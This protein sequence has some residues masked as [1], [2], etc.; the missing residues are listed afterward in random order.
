MSTQAREID[1]QCGQC[2]GPDAK[3][4]TRDGHY[5]RGLETG[6]GHLDDLQVPTLECQNCQHDVA[7]HFTVLAKF[8]RFL[9]DVGQDVLF[10]TGLCQSLRDLSERWSAIL[11][12]SV[13]LRT[14]IERINQIEPLLQDAHHEPI[15][16]VLTVVQFDGIWMTI[17]SQN[18]TVK[19]DIFKP[20]A[21]SPKYDIILHTKSFTDRG[22]TQARLKASRHLC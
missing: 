4:F 19:L 18:E 7:A 11:G 10:G 2:E 12:S 13:G 1:W 5:R 9:L 22:S 6:W 21:V 3:Q 17:Q 20:C 15:T 16:D 8:E 14:L